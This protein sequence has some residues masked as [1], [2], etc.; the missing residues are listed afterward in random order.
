[1]ISFH[2]VAKSQTISNAQDQSRSAPRKL[3]GG[4]LMRHIDSYRHVALAGARAAVCGLL[5]RG[6][7][8]V[9]GEL[10]PATSGSAAAIP[11]PMRKRHRDDPPE[12][13]LRRP[14]WLVVP[15]A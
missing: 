2:K 4:S 14:S 9:G 11:R 3:N 15:R 5:D 13:P 8:D 12:N 1:V 7:L 6:L 10:A